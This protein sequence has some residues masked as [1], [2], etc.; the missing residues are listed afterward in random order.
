SAAVGDRAGAL[1][2]V[3]RAEAL[4]TNDVAAACERQKL[5]GL[6]DYFSRDW[7]SAAVNCEKAVDMARAAGLTYEAMINLHNLGDVLVR[8]NDFP[9]AYGAIQ[10]SLALCDES[11]Y[12]RLGSLNRM[13]LAYLDGVAG[14][15]DAEKLLEQG[16]A[17]ADDNDFV[18]DVIQG[19]M[20]LGSL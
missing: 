17:Y 20:M 3:D 8:L 14:R 18:W 9:R 2:A 12:E 15:T 1:S 7:R 19:E 4:L 10:Q 13:F 11:G 6:V 5:R 16:I